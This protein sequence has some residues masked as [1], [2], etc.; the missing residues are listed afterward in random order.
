MNFV[1]QNVQNVKEKCLDT[2][3]LELKLFVGIVFQIEKTM[4]NLKNLI[5]KVN[6]MDAMDL[7]K[8]LPD[9]CIDLVVTDPPYNMGYSGRGGTKL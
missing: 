9:K 5:N 7:F 8:Q 3:L 6:Q 1:I 2:S 4:N